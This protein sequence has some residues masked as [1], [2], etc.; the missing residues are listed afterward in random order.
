METEQIYAEGMGRM[1]QCATVSQR[2]QSFDDIEFCKLR[3]VM[4]ELF[5]LLHAKAERTIFSDDCW[6]YRL[7]GKDSSRRIMLMSHHDVVGA[8]DADQWAHPPFSGE[9]H[10]GAVWGRGTVDT[11]GPLYAEFRAIEELLQGGWTPPWDLYLLS[12]HNE[13]YGGD[14]C[15]K[16]AAWCEEHGIT[17]DFILD[18]GGAVIAAPMPGISKKCAMIAVHEKGRCKVRC[19]AAEEAFHPGLAPKSDTPVVRMAKFMAN[20]TANP[21]F[22]KRLYPE[23]KAMFTALAPHMSFPL[24]FVFSH[25][26]L[27]GGLLLKLMPKLNP[28]AGAMVGTQCAFNA[29]EGSSAAHSCTAEVFFRCVREEDLE[30]DLKAFQS[31][32]DKYGVTVE[33]VDNEYHPPADLNSAALS[34]VKDCVAAVFPEVACSPFLLPA[35]TDARQFSRQ[36]R[37]VLR[38]APIG[39]TPAQFASVHGRDENL[40]VDALGKAVVFYKYLLEHYE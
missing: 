8:D 38:F 19:T 34:Y 40:N 23:V 13:E 29:V 17:F 9:M 32:A 31:V 11:K 28:Q 39:L 7:P 26:G 37:A 24:S 15:P 1:I 27:F 20:V 33:V 12:S 4:A 3:A 2:D 5:P 25:L 14:G 30:A 18:E 16:A 21:P 6:F 35:G 36:C 22:I 10:D